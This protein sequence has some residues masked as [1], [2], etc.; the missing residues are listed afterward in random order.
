MNSSS[1]LIRLVTI[2]SDC[3]P[4]LNFIDLVRCSL[5]LWAPDICT[6]TQRL[7]TILGYYVVYLHIG[8]IDKTNY[9]LI[10]Q[11]SLKKINLVND[12]SKSIINLSVYIQL[13]VGCICHKLLPLRDVYCRLHSSLV[14]YNV[15]QGH[16]ILQ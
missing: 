7:K 5:L 16:S 4:C 11:P 12:K 1:L 14:A 8:D 9:L 13:T 10:T 2:F 3:P 6:H 15:W